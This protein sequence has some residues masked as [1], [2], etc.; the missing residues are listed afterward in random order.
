VN[1]RLGTLAWLKFETSVGWKGSGCTVR[2][3]PAATLARSRIDAHAGLVPVACTTSLFS[4]MRP[5]MSK[6]R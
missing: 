2:S 3:K 6:F 1:D 4:C 5:T